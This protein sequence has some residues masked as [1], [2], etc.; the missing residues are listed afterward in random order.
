MSAWPACRAVSSIMWINTHRRDTASPNQAVPMSSMARSVITRSAAARARVEGHDVR[1]RLV[2]PD[3]QVGVLV[4][5]VERQGLG[6][7]PEGLAEPVVLDRPQVLDEAEQAGARRG[8]D[9]TSRRFVEALELPQD[10]IAVSVE[11]D[12]QALLLAAGER[13][14][15]D[16][17]CT[18]LGLISDVPVVAETC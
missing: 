10:G 6:L 13:N 1:S 15:L 8:H 11:A 16:H 9:P 3:L 14:S 4:I 17:G 2:Q 5:L 12:V 18:P 7:A